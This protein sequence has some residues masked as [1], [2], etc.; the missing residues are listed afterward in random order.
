MT[1]QKHRY[2]LISGNGRSGTTWLLTMLDTSPE[3]FCRNEPNTNRDS[4]FYE[5]PQALTLQKRPELMEKRWD[6]FVDWTATHLSEWDLKVTAPKYHLHTLPHLFGVSN[7]PF[8]P[9][10]RKLLRIV[11][12]DLWKQEWPLP[13]WMVNKT[14]LNQSC[15]VFKFNI[16]AWYACWLLE[17][18]PEV[19]VLHM[20]RHPG[21]YLHSAITRF[22]SKLSP[23]KAA[24]EYQLYTGILRTAIALD[25][26]WSRVFG[27]ID[28]MDLVEAVAWEWRYHNEVIY[29]AGHGKPNYRR[30]I[31]ED[32]SCEP[33]AIARQVYEHCNLEWS[34]A[35]EGRI[36]AGLD[37][38]VW[39][40]LSK[41]PAEVAEAWK[42]ELSPE[43]LRLAHKVMEKSI[44]SD[45]WS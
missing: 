38:S 3:T 17:Y 22:F 16:E 31:Y 40:K 6:L 15:A 37:K 29:Q 9:K 30:I 12:P 44:M 13:W 36:N 32:L 25:R 42:S 2:A 23:E 1:I 5:L 34:S 4:P 33:L 39:G 14:A 24:K 10:M 26:D 35:I 27:D 18:R 41:S 43:H 20:V 21:G 8:R 11:F 7:W 19:P 28:V 45:W